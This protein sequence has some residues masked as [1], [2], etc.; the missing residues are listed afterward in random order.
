MSKL[1]QTEAPAEAPTELK[2]VVPVKKSV[3]PDYVVCLEDGRKLKMLKRHLRASY[4][5]TPGEYR[6]KW[7]LPADYPMGAPNYAKARSDLAVK[8]GLGK[9]AG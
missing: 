4:N 3:F 7:G 8:L 6:A 2:P 9:R 5:M 1:G